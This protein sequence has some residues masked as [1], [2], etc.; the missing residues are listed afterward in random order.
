M[1]FDQNRNLMNWTSQGQHDDGEIGPETCGESG[2]RNVITTTQ[3]NDNRNSGRVEPEPSDSGTDDEEDDPPESPP[4]PTKASAVPL[5]KDKHFRGILVYKNTV[6]QQSQEL[7]TT[8]GVSIRSVPHGDHAICEV[9]LDPVVGKA[10]GVNPG[11]DHEAGFRIGKITIGIATSGGNAS[12]IGWEPD[13]E[14]FFIGEVVTN[15]QQVG[16]GASCSA[17]PSLVVKIAKA[18]ERAVSSTCLSLKFQKATWRGSTGQGHEWE[19]RPAPQCY[20]TLQ[21]S[22]AHP[23]VHRVKYTVY[24]DEPPEYLL[25]KVRI[26][27]CQP[28]RTLR[29]HFKSWETEATSKHMITLLEIKI[30]KERNSDWF[31]FPTEE[32]GGERR[33]VTADCQGATIVDLQE[34][35]SFFGPIRG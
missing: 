17:N 27:F 29:D 18:R 10:S 9:L 31:Q 23:P 11:N 33:R 13:I 21:M 35:M 1:S 3:G 20:R 25:L 26:Q 24:E 4:G 22:K 16:A 19:Y 6:T 28:C 30:T 2:S 12:D 5:L 15:R 7:I 14:Q 8:I 34:G 32:Q